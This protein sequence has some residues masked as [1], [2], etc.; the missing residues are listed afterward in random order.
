MDHQRGPRE[1]GVDQQANPVGF[2]LGSCLSCLRFQR[3]LLSFISILRLPSHG[4][5]LTAA[6]L[7]F[8]RPAKPTSKDSVLHICSNSLLEFDAV[9]AACFNRCYILHAPFHLINLICQFFATC[10]VSCS[11]ISAQLQ[12]ICAIA[13]KDAWPA[14]IA[15][16]FCFQA[17]STQDRTTKTYLLTCCEF[18]KLRPAVLLELLQKRKFAFDSTSSHPKKPHKASKPLHFCVCSSLSPSVL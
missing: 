3:Q 18:G 8:S 1:W 14:Q 10:H 5:E 7:H 12:L 6:V 17:K 4:A 16:A 2:F 15:A 11:I 13:I 9:S